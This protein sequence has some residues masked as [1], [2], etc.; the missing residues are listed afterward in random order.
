RDSLEFLPQEVFTDVTEGERKIADLVVRASFRNQD[1]LFIIH[2]EHQS[3]SQPEFNR[4][5]FTYFAR[6]HEKFALPVY[7]VVIYSHDS[8]L[9]LEPNSYQVEF[10][11]WKVLEFNYRVIQLNQ[12]QWQDFVN[13]QNP[14]A[15]ALMSKMRMDA[16]E[17]P[18]VKLMSLQLLVS[19]GLN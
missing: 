18:T 15:S 14:V 9:T 7:P 10:P 3:Y 8:P 16:G 2:T 5:M 4:R 12:L 1:A 17:R 19:L 13:Q 11:G 6:L